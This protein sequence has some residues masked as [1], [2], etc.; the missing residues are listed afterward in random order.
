M[1]TAQKLGVSEDTLRILRNRIASRVGIP[2]LKKELEAVIREQGERRA[3][4]YAAK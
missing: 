2:E 3:A 4:R 1:T